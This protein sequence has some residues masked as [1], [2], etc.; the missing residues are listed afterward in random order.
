[1]TAASSEVLDSR[2]KPTKRTQSGVKDEKSQA[3]SSQD[4]EARMK[5]GKRTP[6]RIWIQG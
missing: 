2:M 5:S 1:M 6:F 3:A 4:L